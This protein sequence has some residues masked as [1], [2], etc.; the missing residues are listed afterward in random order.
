M[1][2]FPIR[3]VATLTFLNNPVEPIVESESVALVERWLEL[4]DK[5]LALNPSAKT[6][7]LRHRACLPR[8]SSLC[9]RYARQANTRFLA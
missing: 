5:A 7:T 8:F 9:L 1:A 3:G 2:N 4:G 6:Q